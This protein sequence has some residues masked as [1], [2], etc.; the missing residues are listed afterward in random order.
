MWL[1]GLGVDV[2]FVGHLKLRC[3]NVI[4]LSPTLVLYSSSEEMNSKVFD[5]LLLSL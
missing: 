2:M 5:Y 3:E 4:P 1:V